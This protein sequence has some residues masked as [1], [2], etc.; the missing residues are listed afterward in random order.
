MYFKS[1]GRNDEDLDRLL[2]GGHIC[3]GD[4]VSDVLD[5]GDLL[6]KE[7]ADPD[8]RGFV[9]VLLAGKLYNFLNFLN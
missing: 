7:T 5:H 6:I 1:F 2:Y 4:P 9:R 8:T 3:W